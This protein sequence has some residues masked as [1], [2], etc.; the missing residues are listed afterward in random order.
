[1][2]VEEEI[3]NVEQ[4][5]PDPPVEEARE[6]AARAR[7]RLFTRRK[8]ALFLG[9]LAVLGLLLA[10]LA[11]VSFRYG[12][13]DNYVKAQFVAKMADIGMVFD[14]DVF[15]VTINPLE[16]ELRN[17][18][19]TDKIS[20]EK[21]FFIREARFG[22]SVEDLYAWQLSRDLS[23]DK[24]EISGAEV[25]VKFDE[26]GKSN[27]SNLRLVEDEA[28]SRVNFKYDSVDFTLRDSIVHFGD[29]SRNISGD[30]KNVIF[31]LAPENRAVSEGDASKRY[32]FDLTSTDSTF[33]YNENTVEDI[34]IRATGVAHGNGAEISRFD[35]ITPIGESYLTGSL[36]DW[37]S[38]KYN[39]DIQSTVNLT[40]AS[41]IVSSGTSIIGVGNF[42]GKVSGEGESYRIEGEVDTESLRAGGVSLKGVNITATVEGINTNYEANGTA[43]AQMLTFDD[44]RVDFLK[45]AGNVR[46]TGTDFRWLGELQA[47]AAHAGNKT[48]G[49]LFLSDALAEYKDSQLRAEAGTGR[50]QRFSVGDKE[51]VDLSARNLRFSNSNG[52]TSFTAAN[53]SV[54]SLK[55]NVF[56]LQ[57]MTG[58]NV[59]ISDRQGRT[60]VEI[61]GVRSQ[62][63]T[64]KDSKLRN[65]TADR[66]TMTDRPATTDFTATNLHA[67]RV[68]TDGMRIDGLDVPDV[69]VNDSATQTIVYS[70]KLRVAKVDSGSAV[71]GTLNIAGVRLAIR[72]GRIEA[73]SDDINAGTVTLAKTEAL[74][75]GGSLEAVTIG[76]PVYVLEPSGRYRATA[77]MSL[78]GGALGS[79]ALGS[80]TAKVDA[81][82]DRVALNELTAN[83]MEGALNGKAVIALNTRSRSN[84]T[85]DFTNLDISK[86]LA[87]QGGRVIPI[88]GQTSGKVDLN[89]PGTNFRSASGTLNAD[90]TA[91][92]GTDSSA[93][94]PVSGQVRLSA[95][96][97][98]FNVDT[99]NLRSQNSQLNAAGRFD[100]KDQDSNLTLALRSTDASEIDR[101]MRVLGVS[102]DLEN[103]LDSMQAQ[104][105][106]NLNFDGTVTGNLSDP[107]IDGKASLDSLSMQ[108]RELGSVSTSIFVSPAGLELRDG[109]L[110]DRD[111]GTATFAVNI[112]T[113]V[114]NNTSV[115]ATL[116]NVNAGNLLAALPII[117]PERIRDFTG[118]TS[119]TVNIT[120]LPDNAQG[121]VNLA[122]AKGTIAGQAFDDLNVKA[123]FSGTR[124]N[125]ERVA[126]RVGNGTLNIAGNYDR[127]SELFDVTMG[128]T[129]IP[130][131]LL[132]ALVPNSQSIPV[133]TGDVNF[134]AQ[135]TGDLNRPQTY[136][137]N[138]NGSS[139]NVQ[140][141]EYALGQVAFRGQTVNGVLSADLT[142]SLD[143]RPQVIVA[144]VDLANDVMPF[145]VATDFNQSPLAPFLAFVPSLKNLPITG[146][147]TGRVEFGGNLSG[148]DA[149]GVRVYTAANLIGSAEFSQLAL[150]IQD[151]PLSAAEPV[152]I[153]FNTREINFERARFAGGGS[154][155]TVSGTKA[156][157]DDGTNNL[158]IDGRVNLNLL[159]L[160]TKDTFFA[161]YA[162]TSI[163][164][165]GPNSTAR[166]SG[167]ANVLNG[168]IATFLGSDRFSI[169][170]LK[171][172]VI[173]T[174]NQVEIA[175]AE[176]YLGGGK[177]TGSGGGTLDGLSLQ[178]V[179]FSLD[180][181]NVTV[182]LPQDFITTG[183]AR[184]EIVGIRRNPA[185]DLQLTIRGRVFAR[186]SIYSQDIDLANLLSGRRDPV[187]S[188]GGGSLNPPRFDVVIEGRDALIVRN[189]IADLTA[190][191]S[192]RRS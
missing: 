49:G 64:I 169:E 138:F 42:K 149:N 134:S 73:R 51:F 157:T 170:R 177:F 3:D 41:G 131:P 148:L 93:L 7:T 24:T 32:T 185:E 10:L 122:A 29:L 166:I 40:Q 97:G 114:I 173:F 150:Q 100:L 156:L 90:I 95:V 154:N 77:D 2:P 1:M 136:N 172:R 12:V 53:G 68:E 165:V 133:M 187:L 37:A 88:E 151:T 55:T 34:D 4:G 50:A 142:A 92:A 66:F 13:V 181:R 174:T 96:D 108:G 147:G 83:I 111:G 91:N 159:N 160:T 54:G 84:L 186:R 125:L 155:M 189:N 57:G 137:I 15:R 71:L 47:A 39:F 191:V 19:F 105:A 46:G 69:T 132:T 153:R 87:L 58:R 30:A 175:E 143:G 62:T 61:D 101:L 9:G 168:S 79:V 89:F 60:D 31:L 190:S 141:N 129:S 14:A 94:I 188:G 163:R 72:Q 36:T 140:V 86:L 135:A 26:N 43:I 116:T 171:A 167:T 65:V 192:R 56:G 110:Q 120:G 182:P 8:L 119:G 22:L 99:A 25:W 118:Q 117:L 161:G 67:D 81:N 78:G 80:A 82:N 115:N 180:G 184:L 112:P 70:D 107:T 145:T 179:R 75:S 63:A 76:K 176:G 102:P 48:L 146:T 152:V 21:L 59:R 144:T 126:L 162:D 6:K 113:G 74:P 20:G 38:P 130:F 158:S 103:Q 11:V 104:F 139:P 178:A 33:T 23:I 164:L 109:R 128:G 52:V 27:F 123:V 121:E 124:I 16:L 28:G 183:D 18:T 17:A 127:S 98:L 35:L 44:F 45:L 85:G 5:E 106:G